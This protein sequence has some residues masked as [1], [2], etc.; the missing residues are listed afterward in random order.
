MLSLG[1]PKSAER[2][3][4]AHLWDV[5]QAARRGDHVERAIIDSASVSAMRLA[6]ALRDAGWVHYVLELH[7]ISA[8]PLAAD[9]TQI[10]QRLLQQ[11]PAV[12]RSLFNGYQRALVARMDKLSAEDVEL[13]RAVLAIHVG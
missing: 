6:A 4:S 11:L 3:L 8:L 1:R 2:V 9:S 13:A 5:L 12:N 7:V 10:L